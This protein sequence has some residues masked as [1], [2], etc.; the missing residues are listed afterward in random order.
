VA[1]A[2]TGSGVEPV[3]VEGRDRTAREI[4]ADIRQALAGGAQEI[5]VSD[6]GAKHNLGIAI[7]SP[8][9][10]TFEGSLGYFGCALGDG[11]RAHVRGRAG[12]SLAENLMDGE[13]VV[14]GSSGSSTGAGLRGGTVVVRGNAGARTGISQKGGAIVVGGDSGLLTGFMLQKGRIVILGDVGRACGDS[15]YD[16]E[17]F[18]GGKIASLG[19][20]AIPGEVDDLDAEWLARTLARYGLDSPADWRKVVAGRQLYNYD[21]LEPMERKI[22]L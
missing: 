4:N 10:I 12:W 13:V 16:G 18:V 1:Q 8:C 2:V 14:E 19:T 3:L 21:K 15:M 20:D 22:A 11:I 5:V 7:L 9:R 17:I 6:P